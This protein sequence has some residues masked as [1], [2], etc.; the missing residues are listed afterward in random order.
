MITNKID[1][2][3]CEL[4]SLIDA[5]IRKHLGFVIY[6]LPYSGEMNLVVQTD[7]ELQ[8][9]DNLE[10]LGH[11][12][13]FILS[14]FS[15]A[16]GE[17]AVVIKPQYRVS[18]LDNVLSQL[19]SL[20]IGEDRVEQSVPTRNMTKNEY[21]TTFEMF[22]SSILNGDVDKVV[23]ARSAQSEPID[24]FGKMF[25]RACQSY[26]RLFV[27]LF[28]TPVTGIWSGCSP[29]VLLT[30]RSGNWSTMAIAG[31]QLYSEKAEWDE[32]NRDEQH[33]VESYICSVLGELGAD[34][35]TNGP[36]T[37]RAGDLMHLRTD[38]SFSLP[39]T[40]GIGKILSA[41]HPTPA[42][43][44]RP[45]PSAKAIIMNNESTMRHYY[46]GIVGWI[47][48]D[49]LSQLYVNLRCMMSSGNEVTMYAGGGIMSTSD[50]EKEWQET[51]YKLNT[52]R[53]V[54]L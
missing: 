21:L 10:S 11:E 24:S 26:P 43:C 17:K 12:C 13:G 6:R 48:G 29:E 5:H 16:Y 19:R 50:G 1:E 40:I 53:K 20:P 52:M 32:K 27:Y 46:S 42:V 38:I 31:T 35:V 28:F 22:K 41:L 39:H 51:E 7:G 14:P 37:Q 44:G 3:L 25:V 18:G 54:L 9:Y 23:L 4:A 45:T 8:G 33:I 2:G 30:G 34:I 49:D 36:Y 47:D 15:F